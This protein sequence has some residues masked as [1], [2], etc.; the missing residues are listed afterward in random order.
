MTINRQYSLPNCVLILEGL[1][2]SLDSSTSRPQLSLLTR[3][4]CYFAR[5]KQTLIGGRDLLESLIHAANACAQAWMSGLQSAHRRGDQP[6]AKVQ[7]TPAA[8][9]GFNLAVPRALLLQEAQSV[10]PDASSE[11]DVE[12][13]HLS[14]LQLFDLIEA[15][16]QLAADD[17][18]LPDLAVSIQPRLRQEVVSGPLVVEQVAPI[19]LGTTVVAVAAAALFFMPIPKMPKPP[20]EPQTSPTPSTQT[21]PTAPLVPP[22]TSGTGA[23]QPKPAASVAPASPA[24]SPSPP[25]AS[26]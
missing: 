24:T 12:Q 2:N 8:E 15:I 13:V 17:Q 1:S 14:S 21:V 4:E 23:A 18:T 16:D 7:L 26:P 11:A 3:F 9:G 25:P 20:Q 22:K 6:T 10:S 5:E 19:A